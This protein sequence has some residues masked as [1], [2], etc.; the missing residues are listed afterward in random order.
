[1]YLYLY[2]YLYKMFTAQKATEQKLHNE[3]YMT[4]I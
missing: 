1:M 4:R 3:V 2:Y